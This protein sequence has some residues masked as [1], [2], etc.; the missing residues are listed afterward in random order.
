MKDL[1]QKYIQLCRLFSLDTFIGYISRI[2]LDDKYITDLYNYINTIDEA[3]ISDF[4]S[5]LFHYVENH[6]DKT[7]Y[8]NILNNMFKEV[9]YLARTQLET[10]LAEMDKL[11][12]QEDEVL[13]KFKRRYDE[14][15]RGYFCD[16]KDLDEMLKYF[17][18]QEEFE[19]CDTIQQIKLKYYERKQV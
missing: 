1:K 15:L 5:V 9:I 13:S 8:K 6:K 17:T 16:R 3:S 11:E 19:K 2:S 12:Y 14:L 7:V 4:F 18:E 10:V